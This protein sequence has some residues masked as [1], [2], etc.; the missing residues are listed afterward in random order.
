M[1]PEEVA[2]TANEIPATEVHGANGESIVFDGTTV[3]KFRHHGKDEAARNPVSTFRELQVKENTSLFGKPRTPPAVHR[4]AG[5]VVDH[6]SHRR[7]SGQGRGGI[8]GCRVPALS[9]RQ[10]LPSEGPSKRSM[11]T[12]SDTGR[13]R[14]LVSCFTGLPSGTTAASA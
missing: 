8:H 14:N 11:V 7:R 5:H 13:R 6:E 12:N 4:A 2:V 1:S 3:T 10:R 9:R